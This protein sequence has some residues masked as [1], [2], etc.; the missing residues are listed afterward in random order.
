MLARRAPLFAAQDSDRV[1][2]I[3]LANSGGV[4]TSSMQILSIRKL[5]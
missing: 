1:S 4:N 5:R 2:S 3:R